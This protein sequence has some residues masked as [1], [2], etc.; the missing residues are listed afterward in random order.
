MFANDGPKKREKRKGST[1]IQTK[2][3]LETIPTKSLERSTLIDDASSA[4]EN[5]KSVQDLMSK[6]LLEELR[7]GLQEGSM[8]VGTLT[9]EGRIDSNFK[10][11]P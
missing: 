7:V 2:A 4:E 5:M 8:S 10:V 1:T 6:P 3:T 11:A 9:S